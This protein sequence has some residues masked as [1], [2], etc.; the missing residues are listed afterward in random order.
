[1]IRCD[2]ARE[3]NAGIQQRNGR[4]TLTT[5]QGLDKAYDPKKIL[6]AFKKVSVSVRQTIRFIGRL[7][8]LDNVLEPRFTQ[9]D[10]N[11]ALR[12]VP[13]LAG[14]RMQRQRR[15]FRRSRARSRRS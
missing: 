3:S 14:I 10:A 12:A 5:V 15:L 13:A 11:T 1:V 2:L 9:Y 7:L 4:K 6:K 8:T